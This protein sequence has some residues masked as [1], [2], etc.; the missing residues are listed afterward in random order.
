M[1]VNPDLLRRAW[2]DGFLAMCGVSTT[3][4]WLYDGF[5]WRKKSTSAQGAYLRQTAPEPG[6]IRSG[7]LLPNVDPADTATWASLLRDLAEAAGRGSEKSLA[8]ARSEKGLWGL[9]RVFDIYGDGVAADWIQLFSGV[10]TENP[11]EALVRARIQLR[12][13]EDGD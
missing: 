5:R 10:D 2:P 6:E 8:F 7:D 4:G 13:A 3:R 1:P 12:E 9:Y 11:T